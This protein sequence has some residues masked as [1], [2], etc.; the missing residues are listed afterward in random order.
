MVAA[1]RPNTRGLA[2]VT[3]IFPLRRITPQCSLDGQWLLGLLA[4]TE[5]EFR[6][7]HAK[8][9]LSKLPSPGTITL[10]HHRPYFKR[11]APQLERFPFASA[12]PA[13]CGF[14]HAHNR[15]AT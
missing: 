10:A 2:R 1:T 9:S 5:P 13:Y 6:L 11:S 4:I 7:E 14:I 8:A 3:I 15:A 12:P